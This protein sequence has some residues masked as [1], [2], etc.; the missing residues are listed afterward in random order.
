MRRKPR[1]IVRK[2]TSFFY[3]FLVLAL[4]VPVVFGA[5][6]DKRRAAPALVP[7]PV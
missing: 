6:R 5:A 7:A 2:L 1:H 3:V 4:A